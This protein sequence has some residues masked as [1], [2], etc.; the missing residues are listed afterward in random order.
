MAKKKKK[1]TNRRPNRAPL[2]QTNFRCREADRDLFE[3]ASEVE[4]FSTRTAWMLYHLRRIGK[5]T[6]KR[7]AE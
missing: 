1:A 7:E 4:G 5:E 2:I 3:R 6:V